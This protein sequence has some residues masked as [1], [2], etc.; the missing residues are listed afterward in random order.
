MSVSASSFSLPQPTPR[1]V[2]LATTLGLGTFAWYASPDYITSKGAL[3]VTR[4]ILAAILG[5]LSAYIA[6]DTVKQVRQDISL[7]SP[8]QEAWQMDSDS[9]Q[10]KKENVNLP[11]VTVLASLLAAL[12][13]FSVWFEMSLYRR[14]ERRRARGVKYPH[15]RQAIPMAILGAAGYFLDDSQAD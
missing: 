14:A 10:F 8:D 11:K 5:T 3:R 13:S 2:A 15:T 4:L 12:V 7:A 9:V 1:R 6:D